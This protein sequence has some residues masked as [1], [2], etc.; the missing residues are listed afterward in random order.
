MVELRRYRFFFLKMAKIWVGQMT[1]NG[2]NKGD[3][4]SY[5]MIDRSSDISRKKNQNYAG[6]SGADS[7]K[8]RPI[9]RD[10]SGKNSNFEGCPG[11]NS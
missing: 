1:L 2:G 8:N 9:S 6:F 7:R 4:H 10:F 3:G 11:A 5:H